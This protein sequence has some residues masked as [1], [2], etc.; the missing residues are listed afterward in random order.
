MPNV[1]YSTKPHQPSPE[2][3][4]GALVYLR[5]AAGTDA[6]AW[7]DT[8]GKSV[9]ES[10]F[11]IL[12]AAACEPDT[13]ALTRHDDHHEMVAQG[14]KLIVETE[15]SV[16]GQLGRPSGARFRTYERLKKYAESLQGTL[17]ANP[18]LNKAIEDIYKY[19]LLQSAT[20]ILNRQLKSGIDDPTLAD[21]V[22]SLRQDAR[23][24]RVSD[25]DDAAE[26]QVICSLGLASNKGGR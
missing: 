8:Q 21:L 20:D 18:E 23:L 26:P 12:K 11:A 1:V 5:T 7:V 4:E 19:P 10:Q 2:Q 16:G 3:P 6:L 14:V 13:P 17:L 22:I 15:K 24:C 25:E 9:T